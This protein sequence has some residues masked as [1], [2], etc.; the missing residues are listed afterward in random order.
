MH[1]VDE[2]RHHW[3]HLQ[4]SAI[5]H[6][7]FIDASSYISGQWHGRTGVRKFTIKVA[8]SNFFSQFPHNLIKTESYVPKEGHAKKSDPTSLWL[9]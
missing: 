3:I 7:G 4:I 1:I 2:C 6:L 8:I 9:K 5:I